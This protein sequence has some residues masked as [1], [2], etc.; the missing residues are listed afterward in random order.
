MLL[1]LY[2]VPSIASEKPCSV[3]VNGYKV[4]KGSVF[5]F[6]S[7]KEKSCFFAFYTVNPDPTVDVRG[8]GNLGDTIWYG[9]Y[10]RKNPDTIYELP[11]PEGV[12]WSMVCT[13]DAIS[14]QAMHNHKNSD[15]TV[16]GSCENSP[17]NY[18][19]AFVFTL[20]GNKYLLDKE[21]YNALYAVLCLTV[22]DVRKYIKNPDTYYEVLKKRGQ[23]D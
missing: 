7:G 12:D 14:F 6:N 3:K 11:K 18:T 17:R 1:F 13:I 21:T 8:N 23:E 4:V 9:Y 22:S 19:V 10:Y 15:I 5:P 16:I 20:N 2:A